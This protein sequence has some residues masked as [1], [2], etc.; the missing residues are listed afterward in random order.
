MS[1]AAKARCTPEWRKTR[2]EMLETKLDTSTIRAMYESGM[3]QDEIAKELGVTQKV[4]WRHM[5]NHGIKA[6]V[7]AKRNQ[8]KEA[9]CM[10]KGNDAKYSAFHLRVKAERGCARNYGCTVCGRKDSDA[11]YDWANL[12]GKYEDINDYA[13]MCRKC[14]RQY[15][16]K[17]REMI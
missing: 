16:A 6:R 4:I 13:S 10:W 2:S 5:R 9:N 8:E 14:H 7:A 3:T 15:D 17:R 12:T 11:T 1:E